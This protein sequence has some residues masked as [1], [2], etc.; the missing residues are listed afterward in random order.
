MG[1]IQLG[2]GLISGMDIQGTVE[3]L[4]ALES[5]VLKNLQV[6]NQKFLQQQTYISQLTSMFMTSNYMIRNLM[7]VS[8][9]DRRDV[10]SS[11]ESLLGVA[12]NGNPPP[13]THTFTPVRTATQHQILSSGIK[14]AT[15]PL[16]INGN[17]TVR[18]GRDLETNFD[19]RDLN[20]G[21]GFSR[22]QVRITDQ[23]GARAIIDLRSATTMRDVLDAINNNTDI[24]VRA[25]MDG[26]R[27]KLTDLSGQTGGNLIVQEVAGGSTAASLGLA[28]INTD[29]QT[30]VG[31]QIVRLGM[32]LELRALHDGN[33]FQCNSF[34]SDLEITLAN[35]TVVTIDF[36]KFTQATL[37]KDESGNTVYDATGKA[38]IDVPAHFADE[39]TLGDL[40]RTITQNEQ[41]QGKLEITISDD[42]QRL[43]WK[44][45]TY[46]EP[47]WEP[48]E[49]EELEE[50]EEP[51]EE[52]SEEPETVLV[53]HNQ[54]KFSVRAINGSSALV[55]LGL[56]PSAV[57]TGISSNNGEMTSARLM[58][59]L[60]SVL[61]TSLDGGA[62]IG[63][64]AP[65]DATELT[66][67]VKNLAG[68]EAILE[69]S[70]ME[71]SDVDTLDEYV[72]LMNKKLQDSGMDMKVQLNSAKTGLEIKD[73][74]NGYG[75]SIVFEDGVG[76]LVSKMKLTYT[77]GM[78]YATR[79]SQDLNLQVVSANTK[80]AD[81][82]GGRGIDTMGSM[83]IVDSRGN[84]GSITMSDEI[85]TV[86]DLIR[87]ISSNGGASVVAEI[88][89]AGDGIRIIDNAGGTG[90][91]A[92][93]EG[94][95]YS[96]M[97]SDLHFLQ[98]AQQ[99]NIYGSGNIRYVID[100]SMTYNLEIRES[101]S[102]TTIVENLNNMG[103]GI[104]ASIFN[105][106]S[107]R[108]YRLMVGG[109]HTGEAAKLTL[110][111][112]VLG[113]TQEVMNEARDAVLVYGDMNAPNAVMLTS[114]TNIFT[115][116]VP[117]IN[118]EVKGSSTSPITVSTESSSMEIKTSLTSYVENINKF[119]EVLLEATASDPQNN[120]YGALFTDTTTRNLYRDLT[121]MLTERFASTKGV[122]S[123]MQ[124]GIRINAETR[125]LEFDEDTFDQLYKEN[126]EGIREFFIKSTVS[127]YDKDGNPIEAQIG[128]AAKYTE[129][130]ERYTAVAG[131]SLGY[132]YE[133]L[134]MKIEDANS[135]E[136]FLTARLNAKY[137]RLYKSFITMETTLAK[138]Q[139]SMNT[140][141]GINT[142]M[143]TGSSAS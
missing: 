78:N 80:L 119:L 6:R 1:S 127:D 17:V 92:I 57:A 18:Y 21:D 116:A 67:N 20:G 94:N 14:S 86:G 68:K 118:I 8:V 55:S 16:G 71:V 101:D 3:K 65:G 84:R 83:T 120:E 89:P 5:G 113:L 31:T 52:G 107:S 36:S 106:G 103:M 97:A 24:S 110:D 100:G 114:S 141:S 125:L 56:V 30:A 95:S 29:D 2:V 9:F 123:L 23:S 143:S 81:L 138:L 132:K 4:I 15:E 39:I 58:G 93:Y 112:S 44:D 96:T 49:A 45:L 98:T 48:V 140:I 64:T 50:P 41:L 32:N 72:K 91:M 28:G 60:G 51:E 121:G 137:L 59:S 128:F 85:V 62:G 22:G 133:S 122:E 61:L 69:F 87:A 35:G 139:K 109:G 25:E 82:N 47:T 53:D 105:D 76:D 46:R 74:S 134:Q 54:A 131:G 135:R 130:A 70:I 63:F 10:K 66:V 11:N 142:S 40:I 111:L 33:G 115:N 73:A 88:N 37:K 129:M 90:V 104:Q 27:L 99:K 26:D 34:S 77:S 12:R 117:N 79:V 38:V 19:L 42:G 108:P 124:L 126:A 43:V 75:T 7:K 102:L 136:D 13:G